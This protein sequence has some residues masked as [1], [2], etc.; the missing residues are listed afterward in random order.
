MKSTPKNERC[1]IQWSHAHAQQPIQYESTKS[2]TRTGL[3]HMESSFYG[4]V[5]RKSGVHRVQP[6]QICLTI[7]V[8]YTDRKHNWIIA[9]YTFAGLLTA[10]GFKCPSAVLSTQVQC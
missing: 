2:L 1:L 5:V 10:I 4:F 7:I 6:I 9:Y 8:Q 3:F